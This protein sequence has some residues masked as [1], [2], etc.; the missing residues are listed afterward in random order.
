MGSGQRGLK[1]WGTGKHP[2]TGEPAAIETHY[3]VSWGNVLEVVQEELARQAADVRAVML[4]ILAEVA[5]DTA[6]V[7]KG[8]MGAHGDVWLYVKSLAESWA[9][10]C[11]PTKSIHP[12]PVPPAQTVYVGETLHEKYAGRKE[13]RGAHPE[14]APAEG[15]QTVTVDND[16]G[17]F[18][19]GTVDVDGVRVPMPQT[20]PTDTLRAWREGAEAA[21][22][23]TRP[24]PVPAGQYPQGPSPGKNRRMEAKLDRALKMLAMLTA[25]A[26]IATNTEEHYADLGDRPEHKT[27]CTCAACTA[28]PLSGTA[29]VRPRPV[30]YRRT[31][32]EVAELSKNPFYS[33]G[34]TPKGSVPV[35]T[36]KGDFISS[37]TPGASTVTATPVA[38]P[39]AGLG[40][41]PRCE[42]EEVREDFPFWI[43]T[44]DQTGKEVYSARI[45]LSP[46]GVRPWHNGGSH[47]S[48]EYALKMAREALEKRGVPKYDSYEDGW[49]AGRRQMADALR[50]VVRKHF[51][52]YGPL[53][54][55]LYG[56]IQREEHAEMGEGAPKC[57]GDETIKSNPCPPTACALADE[58]GATRE[59]LRVGLRAMAYEQQSC[60]T[61][62]FAFL[63][64]DYACADD[65]ELAESGRRLKQR[66]LAIVAGGRPPEGDDALRE[67]VALGGLPKSEDDTDEILRLGAEVR[68][69]VLT[70]RL[71]SARERLEALRE[72][73]R[74]VSESLP[75]FYKALG[76][77][78]VS[79]EKLDT[80]D[81]LDEAMERLRAALGEG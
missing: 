75:A 70:R 51:P 54:D 30:V 8:S 38:R 47:E 4:E 41:V 1:V 5:H 59:E 3:F 29:V 10:K 78:P 27:D 66:L 19:L 50:G 33:T 7:F 73:A 45:I 68:N 2:E 67:A 80:Q 11:T 9:K 49:H 72:A 39:P 58:D 65:V 13:K 53:A 61:D 46:T 55:A 43:V 18:G 24:A 23:A 76:L 26:T 36:P 20:M 12:D 60:D 57:E 71:T 17:D 77:I 21:V 6:R 25:G 63:W 48:K 81:R 62:L 37:D 34:I 22:R 40:G 74:A 28:P 44:V 15:V 14:S 35:L 79:Q 69:A 42:P 52:P 31:P 56:A 16:T 64:R 32:E